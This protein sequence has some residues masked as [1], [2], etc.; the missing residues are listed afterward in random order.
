MSHR[1]LQGAPENPSEKTTKGHF[2][3]RIRKDNN[4]CECA[5]LNEIVN[6][7]GGKSVIII[8]YNPDVARNKGKQLNIK[9]KDRID[10]L[11]KTIKDELVKNYDTF[12]V[13]IIQIYYPLESYG[14]YMSH[15]SLQG[16][17]ENPRHK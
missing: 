3:Y 13:K 5:R 15:R 11:V 6:G 10:I 2:P 4:T 1:S 9:Q 17:P 14:T 16:A 12:V 7:I 8:R